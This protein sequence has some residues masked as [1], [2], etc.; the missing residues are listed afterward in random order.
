MG[1]F[2]GRKCKGEIMSL[3]D[4][5]NYLNNFK[6]KIDGIYHQVPVDN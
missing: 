4:N 5:H 2:E 1:E 6:N 3:Y